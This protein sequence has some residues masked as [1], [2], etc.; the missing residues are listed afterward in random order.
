MFCLYALDST[1]N[2][3]EARRALVQSTAIISESTIEPIV[4]A[5]KLYSEEIISEY[6]YK[7]VRD[8]ASRDTNE[9]RLETILD[10][11]KDRV[12]YDTDIFTKFVK[13]VRE[14]LHQSDL[15]NKIVD[16]VC[17]LSSLALSD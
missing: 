1:L 6:V 15:A 4:L 7:R 14:G 9:E 3:K 2:S 10:E 11:I 12:K 16:K 5:R 13:I 8:K 17:Y